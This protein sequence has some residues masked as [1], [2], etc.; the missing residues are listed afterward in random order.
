MKICFLSS[1]NAVC[2]IADTTLSLASGLRDFGNQIRIL[3]NIPYGQKTDPHCQNFN[4]REV[5]E[6]TLQSHKRFFDVDGAVEFVKDCDVLHVQFESAL[7][8]QE[9]LETFLSRVKQLGIPIF[10]T[11]HSSC[12]WPN[13]NFGLFNGRVT[14]NKKLA[15]IYDAT[16]I[17]HGVPEV[18]YA[19]PPKG[20]YKLV[21]FG[22]G[23]NQDETVNSTV[24]ELVREGWKI[25]FET[26]YGHHKWT[27]QYQL[28]EWV[29]QANAVVLYYPEQG[30]I[31][32]SS[33]C[34]VALGCGRPVIASKTSWF[35]DY[36]YAMV[37]KVES[38]DTLKRAIIDSVQMDFE[39]QK[40]HTQQLQN[41]RGWGVVAKKYLEVYKSI[42]CKK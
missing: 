16:Y 2:G 6:V 11:L 39:T 25:K 1:F 22:L 9:L 30:A 37:K 7:Y 34:A 29:R 33:A 35:D 23:R 19:P 17:P 28:Y 42:I 20:E 3:A 13:L 38:E 21:S 26:L 15:Q 31:V 10:V 14:P 41:E 27:P 8:I 32:T 4:V 40:Q 24:A 5:F 12:I 18:P 36:D